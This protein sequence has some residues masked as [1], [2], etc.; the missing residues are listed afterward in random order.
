M[1]AAP[2]QPRSVLI[3]SFSYWPAA[4][5]RSF[6]WTA[7]AEDW[8]RRGMRVVV[9][10]A[11]TPGAAEREMVN[12]VQVYRVGI[13]AVE[14][15]RA[16]LARSR[17]SAPAQE[18]GGKAAQSLGGRAR[19]AAGRAIASLWQR[20][21][22]PDTACLWYF[23][24]LRQARELARSAPPDAV[25]SVSPEFTAVAV[26][27]ALAGSRSRQ[28]AWLIDLGDPFSFL[29]EAPPNNTRLYAGLNRKFERKCLAGASAVTVTNETTAQ[30][31]RELFPECAGKLHVIPPL[32]TLDVQPA[33]ASTTAEPGP[34]RFV[35]LGR[36]YRTIRRPDFLLALFAGLLERGG[37]ANCELHFYGD[38]SECAASFVPYAPLLGRQ[39]HLH[40]PIP[41]SQVPEAMRQATVLVNIANTTDY[42]LPSKIVEYAVAGKPILNLAATDADCSGKFLA[43][44]PLH[45][46]LLAAA[47]GPSVRDYDQVRELLA[48][49]RQPADPGAI[50]AWLD[51][52]RLPAVSA[53]YLQILAGAVSEAAA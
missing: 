31:Y 35:Y 1:T 40:G 44:Y 17:Q 39:I 21:Y 53:S 16:T 51:R 15:L 47:G 29:S 5:A 38:A 8:A 11:W 49:A 3:V 27:R 23:P 2:R 24:A 7:L 12:G 6:R 48:R 10:C 52:Y 22:W 42:Q 30:R 14:R 37:G 13:R 36:L 26:G 34:V 9:V 46:T 45:L 41:R 43:S 20:L 4:N 25:I 18:T 19:R 28:V 33:T 32:L 50:S